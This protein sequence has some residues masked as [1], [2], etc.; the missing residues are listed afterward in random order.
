VN[1]FALV[2]TVLIVSLILTLAMTIADISYRQALLSN[3]AKDSQVAFY[4]ADAALEC[5]M[6]FDYTLNM[7]PRSTDGD[8][9]TPPDTIT[10]GDQTLR[11]DD[12]SSGE[13]YVY[14]PQKNVSGP[15]FT[16]T[17]DKNDPYKKVVT[18]DGFNI[19]AVNDRQVERTLSLTY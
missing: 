3:L 14:T 17:F 19:C 10:C 2:F 18:G 11:Y 5:G 8:P 6:Y 15:C 9:V 7:F 12:S 16:I 4:Q 1:G 13:K